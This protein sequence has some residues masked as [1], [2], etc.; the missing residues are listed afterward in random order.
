MSPT[1][2]RWSALAHSGHPTRNVNRPF[3][4]EPI[5]LCQ[6]RQHVAFALVVA[7][8]SHPRFR[9][10]PES[11]Q[12]IKDRSLAAQVRASIAQNDQTRATHLE[13]TADKG[14]VSL[15]GPVW[16]AAIRDEVMRV[17]KQVPGV[18]SVSDEEVV[19]SRF[20]SLLG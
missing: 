1:E 5:Y 9:P 12:L 16:S 11:T 20:H 7:L 3:A 15:K 4:T 18:L 8:A 17:A 6:E 13:A 2:Q 14:H 10:T 19:I